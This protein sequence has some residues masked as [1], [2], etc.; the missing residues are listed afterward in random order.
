MLYI[1]CFYC[2]FIRRAWTSRGELDPKRDN[3]P[4][5]IEILKKRSEQAKMH[6]YENFAAYATADTMAGTPDAV[7][8]LLERVWAPAKVSADRE[9][10]ALE[11]FVTESGETLGESGVQPWDWR[12]YAERVRKTKYDL[13]EDEL[14]PYFSLDRMVE[15]IFDCANKLFGLKFVRRADIPSYHPDV[16]TY[17]V[18]ET[19]GGEER[20]VG[21]FLHGKR[22]TLFISC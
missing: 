1:L 21:I 18:M 4:L 3:R 11:A 5:A 7:M 15:A 16:V 12:Y 14:K 8:E 2:V 22:L 9:R 6:G 20:L 10:Q 13:D 17:E 19:V